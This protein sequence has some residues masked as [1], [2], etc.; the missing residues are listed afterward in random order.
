MPATGYCRA[1]DNDVTHPLPYH[2]NSAVLS[3]TGTP[4]YKYV[5]D[6]VMPGSLARVNVGLG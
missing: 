5:I 3:V 4:A 2:F 6:P 1:Q